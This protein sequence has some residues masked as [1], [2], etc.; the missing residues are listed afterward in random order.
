MLDVTNTYRKDGSLVQRITRNGVDEEMRFDGLTS[1]RT[2]DNE[3]IPP[4]LNFKEKDEADCPDCPQTRKDGLVFNRNLGEDEDMISPEMDMTTGS[5]FDPQEVARVHNVRPRK[6]ST[7]SY[8]TDP[9]DE[10]DESNVVN[11]RG[12]D[13]E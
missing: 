8:L 4:T 1:E 5:A 6:P 2:T 3:M 9:D 7:P 11:D 12:G 13:D 10:W